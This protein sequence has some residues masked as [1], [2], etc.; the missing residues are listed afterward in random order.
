MK[1]CINLSIGQTIITKKYD[2]D[3]MTDHYGEWTDDLGPGVI[4]RYYKEF[5]ER[6]PTEMERDVDGRFIGKAEPEIPSRGNEY[7][8]FK[9]ANHIPF[10]PKDWAGVPGTTK[11]KKETAYKYALEDYQRME[12]LN[13]G[14]WYYLGITFTTH[15]S[16]DKLGLSGECFDSLWGIE[17]DSGDVY[18]G[19]IIEELKSNVKDQLIALGFTED[20]IEESFDN[21]IAKGDF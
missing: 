14:H 21:A 19:G 17:S 18:I 10:D 6:I 2:E 9:P 11:E 16:S 4:I 12:D 5:Y 3:P 20:E 1:K 8:G 15:Y 13:N 7:R